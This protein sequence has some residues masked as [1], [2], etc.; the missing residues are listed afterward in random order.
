MRNPANGSP[1]GPS[2]H[3]PIK[4][5]HATGNYLRGM[6]PVAH[7]HYD[8]RVET[9]AGTSSYYQQHMADMKN[10]ARTTGQRPMQTSGE[11]SLREAPAPA[12]HCYK[13]G[14]AFPVERAKFCCTCGEKR[15]GVE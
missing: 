6:R 8:A 7:M 2:H 3:R 15:F 5:R 10:R 1:A 11:S 12:K 4:T 13:C 14:E 9:K